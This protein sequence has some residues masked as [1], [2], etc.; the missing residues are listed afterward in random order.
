[1]LREKLRDI[2]NM[3]IRN[4]LNKISFNIFLIYIISIY[5]I[6]LIVLYR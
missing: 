2:S 3:K 5:I 4:E 6:I 1:M